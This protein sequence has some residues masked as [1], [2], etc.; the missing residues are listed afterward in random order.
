M[1]SIGDLLD[2]QTRTR[3]A[4]VVVAKTDAKAPA[5]E[6]PFVVTKRAVDPNPPRPLTERDAIDI[7]PE[8][9]AMIDAVCV[10]CGVPIL[11]DP[12]VPEG[13]DPETP[14]VPICQ[15]HAQERARWEIA[16]QRKVEAIRRPQIAKHQP[17]TTD[18]I[19]HPVT[20]TTKENRMDLDN[21]SDAELG[22]IVRRQMKATL[23][24]KIIEGAPQVL[25][26]RAAHEEA[27]KEAIAEVQAER[28][29]RVLPGFKVGTTL[30]VP[31]LDLTNVSN[32]DEQ[33]S[34]ATRSPYNK[35]RFRLTGEPPL[36]VPDK[37]GL[38]AEGAVPTTYKVLIA[39]HERLLSLSAAHNKGAAKKA[40]KEKVEVVMAATDAATEARLTKATALAGVLGVSVDQALTVM[41]TSQ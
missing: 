33:P 35:A 27:E 31:A 28:S 19:D 12:K 2:E 39:E 36:A 37:D 8:S 18:G 16:Q 15:K 40:K 10:D 3:L 17:R 38:M 9:E 26:E 21:L 20:V 41:E 29:G 24:E 7:D 22:A 23:T 32:L 1:S 11:I 30:E 34:A 5:N 14:R 6:I 4:T 13:V 25:A